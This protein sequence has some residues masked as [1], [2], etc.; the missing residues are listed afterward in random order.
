MLPDST[1]AGIEIRPSLHETAV[2][3]QSRLPDTAKHR[4]KLYCG[5]MFERDWMDATVLFVN[6][7]GFDD[8]LM[9][10]VLQKL[11]SAHCGTKVITLSAVAW[12]PLCRVSEAA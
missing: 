11:H 3:V 10:H 2:K 12:S 6:S 7:T 8:N 1:A 5:D 4:V 9:E